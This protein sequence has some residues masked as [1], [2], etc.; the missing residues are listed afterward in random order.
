MGDVTFRYLK[1][2][3]RP[4]ATYWRRRFF[5]LAGGLAIF[6][7]LAWSV[8]GAIGGVNTIRPAANVVAGHQHR[9]AGSGGRPGGAGQ[10][11]A[12]APSQSATPSPQ[13]SA[14]AGHRPASHRRQHRAASPHPGRQAKRPA[15]PNGGTRP[16]RPAGRARPKPH[17]RG[18]TGGKPR[19]CA[20]SSIVI[21]LFASQVSYPAHARPVFDVDVVSTRGKTCTFNVGAA[22]LALVIKAGNAPVWSSADCLQGRKS[23]S[24]DL[25][26]GVPTV[27]SISW[28]RRTSAPG[29]K[30][31]SGA[32]PA[33]IYT[34]TVTS[35]TLTS[36][37][38]IF[39]IR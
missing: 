35:G 23:L 19:A 20:R 6:A 1:K 37:K 10:A 9:P 17:G 4:A 25:V 28:D 15:R 27:L 30:R 11:T 29:C 39:R 12:P 14:R 31:A 36:N 24:T 26:K 13:P 8:S 5:A 7:L 21:S 32:V 22:Y 34:A 38:E 2:E 16:K 3:E 18:S 33:G